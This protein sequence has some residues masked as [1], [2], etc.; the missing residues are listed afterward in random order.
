MSI[1]GFF[2]QTKI[3]RCGVP[4]GSTLGP[5]LFLIYINDLNNALDKCRVHH[6]ADDTNLLFG[7]KC[8]SEISCV[9][10][11]ELKLL[12]DWLRANKLSLNESKTK[13]LIFRPHRKLNITIPNIKL[14]SF[15]LTP[16]K[17]ITYLSIEIDENL[18]WNKQIEILAKKLSRTNSILL[19]LRY[20]VSK[21]T[22]TSVYYSLFQLYIVNGSTVWCFMSQKNMKNFVLQK[23]CMRLLTFSDYHE[24][25][26]PIFKSLK[27]LKLQDIIKFGILKIIYF[28]FND[29]LPLQVKNIF[30]KNE[31][32]NPYNTRGGKLFFIPQ[33]HTTHF[34][35]KSLRYNGSLTWNNSQS[36]NNNNLFNV[37]ISKFKNFLKDLLLENY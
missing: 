15:I 4:Q 24:H 32:V 8:P 21:K 35:T 2:S 16:E 23:K 28:Y 29:Q 30:I 5:L 20:Y 9:M 26:S 31:S 11:N 34:G 33:V 27:V 25:T 36:M 13:L 19:N 7:N 22:L 3:V 12:T 14:N 37:G 17:S 6:F 18:S 10:N 1:S